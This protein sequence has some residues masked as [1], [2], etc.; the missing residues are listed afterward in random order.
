MFL[1][2]GRR[3]EPFVRWRT[4]SSDDRCKASQTGAKAPGPQC[5]P[6]RP[7]HL[8]SKV[9]LTIITYLG[10]L[11][12]EIDRK[13]D[14]TTA[15]SSLLLGLLELALHAVH[16]ISAGWHFILLPAR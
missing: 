4:G 9:L 10:H 11:L 7:R 8:C 15:N 3:L 14:M 5:Q 1:G 13:Q 16:T 6:T 12:P 2:S